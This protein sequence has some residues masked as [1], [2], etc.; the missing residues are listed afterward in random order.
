[1]RIV[2]LHTHSSISDGS[3]TPTEVVGLAHRMGLTA[4]ALTDHD[5]IAG[6]AEARAE[7]QRLDVDFLTG[8]EMSVA[9]RDRNLH[10]VAL[11][12]DETHPEFVKAYRKIRTFKESGIEE[13]VERICALGADISMEK[14]RQFAAVDTVDRY[15]IMR[16]FVSLHLFDDVQKIWDT[17]INPALM[18]AKRNIMVE[19]ALAAVKMAGG[20]TSL[21]HY[22]KR[23]GL[24]GMTRAEQEEAIVELKALGLGGMETQ[25]PSYTLEEQEFASYLME[26]HEMIPTG[27][28]DFHGKNRPGV[29]LGRGIEHNIAVLYSVY[30]HL[31]EHIR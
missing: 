17:Y 20:V 13:L 12:F 31:I 4:L 18:G 5:T 28:S 11:G 26:K 7:A 15:A 2:D 10:I 14:V 19:E 8:M 29:E 30:E 23:L 1:M 24:S 3:Y 27:G 9:Y 6:I 25:Y 22:H 16:Y 21:A